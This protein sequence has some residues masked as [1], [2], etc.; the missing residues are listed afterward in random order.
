[1]AIHAIRLIR[2]LEIERPEQVWYADI[3]Y[4]RLARGFVYLAVILDVYT[5]LLRC[6]ALKQ[7]LDES[8]TMAALEM[9]LA[10]GMPEVHHSDQGVQYC[11]QAYAAALETAGVAVSMAATGQP[12]RNAYAERWIGTLKA[13]G[14]PW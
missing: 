5:R 6:W 10:T 2:G 1:M 7:C 4:I 14:L 3:T 13:E 11:G 8:L 9:V 12:T